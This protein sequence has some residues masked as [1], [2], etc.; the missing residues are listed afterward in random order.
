MPKYKVSDRAQRYR[1]DLPVCFEPGAIV[2]VQDIHDTDVDG[3]LDLGLEEYILPST[4]DPV[5]TAADLG[6][7][8]YLVHPTNPDE[9]TYIK[10][11]GQ[12]WGRWWL[13]QSVPI[14]FTRQKRLEND[15]KYFEYLLGRG[16][17]V[18]FAGVA[19]TTVPPTV[20]LTEEPTA[21][22]TAV[23]VYGTYSNHGKRVKVYRIDWPGARPD[24]RWVELQES[25]DQSQPQT[26]TI[27]T[28]ELLLERNPVAVNTNTN[29]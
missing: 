21:L 9:P 15:P 2:D 10:R 6:E 25:S 5:F 22:G 27:W 1:L 8:A 17:I 28:W 24:Q 11:W 14:S 3:E 4:L 18:A 29:P 13:H 7:N 26:F 16:F 23:E 12:W 20:P 19:P